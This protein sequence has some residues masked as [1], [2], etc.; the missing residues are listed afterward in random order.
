[1]L[2]ALDSKQRVLLGQFVRY[3]IT[4]G[5]VTALAAGV[6]WSLATF[7]GVAPLIANLAAYLVAVALGFVMHSRWSFQG[8]DRGD[9]LAGTSARF[10]LVSLASLGLNSLWVW[11]LTGLMDGPTWWPIV[12]MLVATPVIV[13]ALN[14]KFV[15]GLG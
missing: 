8:H 7:A 5:L 10:F 9:D 13:F 1:M 6:Y 3:A 2:G 14:R 4:G 15:F 12:P 11:L